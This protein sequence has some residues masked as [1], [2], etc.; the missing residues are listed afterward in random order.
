MILNCPV[1]VIFKPI[2]LLRQRAERV[3]SRKTESI[4]GDEAHGTNV[5]G[6]VL[7]MS[8]VGQII[9]LAFLVNVMI[10]VNGIPGQHELIDRGPYD[11]T[12]GSAT[13]IRNFAR[14]IDKGC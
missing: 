3:R 1:Q 8:H 14:V 2:Q 9:F 12:G 4:Q 11:L 10:L 5:K 6:V 7:V 13:V